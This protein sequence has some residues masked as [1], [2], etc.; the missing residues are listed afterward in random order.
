[1]KRLMSCLWRDE[2]G[3]ILSTEIVVVGSV[4]VIGLITGMTCLQEAVN[5]EMEDLAG[6]FSSLDQSYSFAGQVGDK[7]CPVCTAGSSY[8]DCQKSCEDDC[9]DIVASGCGRIIPCGTGC[10]EG[11]GC[12]A[13]GGCGSAC[14]GSGCFGGS[15]CG[16]FGGCGD[17]G[18]GW[19]SGPSC[20]RTGVPRMKVTEW[21]SASVGLDAGCDPCETTPKKPVVNI[22][23][24]VW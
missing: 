5:G 13:C 12:G 7:R 11:N 21:P 16:G 23:D 24:N 17:A 14:G 2:H 3:V 10:C 4:L 9:G 18:Y 1:M 15:G 20:V 6:A 19:Q 8:H 22:P